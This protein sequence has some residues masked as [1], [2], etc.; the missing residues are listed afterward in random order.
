MTES[1]LTTP[2]EVE[3]LAAIVRAGV[4]PVA[5]DLGKYWIAR[6]AN[7]TV[8]EL[9]LTGDQYRTSP[10]RKTGITNVRDVTSFLHY[11]DKHQTDGTSEIYADLDRRT[12]TAVLDA[13][14]TDTP[15]W[16]G[17]ILRLTLRHH[18]SW[19]AWTGIS[20]K[21][22]GQ[23]QFAEFIEDH[24]PDII[25]PVSADVLELAQS[26]QATVKAEFKSGTILKSGQRELQFTET[27]DAQAGKQGRLAIPDHI[28]LALPVFDADSMAEAVT[29]RFRY[30]IENGSLRLS[31]IL[32]D[33][34]EKVRSAF[35]AVV[36]EIN[37]SVEVDVLNGTPA[38]A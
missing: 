37:D 9:D 6:D 21:L 1:V 32:D 22:M 29:A 17:H 2:T 4:E 18:P 27:L 7:G 12:I 26:F 33:V 38:G 34:D 19:T 8:Q 31:L 28:R 24:R 25:E 35:Q 11:W 10:A 15:G 23:Q 13:H 36:G 3:E 30:R 5:L 20:G 16:A 14:G